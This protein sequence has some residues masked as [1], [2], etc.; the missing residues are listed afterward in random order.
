MEAILAQQ[1]A[2][3]ALASAEGR[4]ALNAAAMIQEQA[5]KRQALSAQGLT[6]A[7]VDQVMELQQ[8]TMTT[9]GP[10]EDSNLG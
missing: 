6:E 5:V 2:S 8:K 3:L 10:S 4:E 9:A 7:Q 1:G